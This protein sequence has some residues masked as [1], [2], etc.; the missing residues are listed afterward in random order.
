MEEEI[1][2]T[3]FILGQETDY[4]YNF[5][6]NNGKAKIFTGQIRAEDKTF[7]NLEEI[8][9]KILNLNVSLIKGK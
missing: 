1:G 6:V 2:Q 9:Q 3:T 8:E 5:S 7:I 4:G